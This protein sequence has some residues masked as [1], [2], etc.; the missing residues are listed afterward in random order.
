MQQ[1]YTNYTKR[2]NQLKKG[3]FMLQRKKD[4][5]Y[6]LSSHPLKG[7]RKALTVRHLKKDTN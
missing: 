7:S 1:K 4:K 3:H 5:V 2:S 6:T